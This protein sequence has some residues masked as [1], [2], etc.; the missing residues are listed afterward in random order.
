MLAYLYLDEGRF[1]FN[2]RAG[3]PGALDRSLA[4]ARRAVALDPDN[5]RALQ[6]LMVALFFHREVTEGLRVGERALALNP[7]DT[8]LMAE[9]GT[10][11]AQA[12]EW[13]RGG[14]LVAEALAR[15]PAHSGFY[16]GTLALIDYMRCDYDRALAEI[17]QANLEKFSLYH[18]VAAVIYAQE[19]LPAEARAAADRFVALQPAFVPNLDAELAERN[20]PPRD[21]AHLIDGLR[22]AGLAVPGAAGAAES[23]PAC[24]PGVPHGARAGCNLQ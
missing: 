19:G 3:R 16:R 15:N 14:R 8:E 12:G 22:K 24:E 2:P 1:A 17:R 5:I 10:R 23:C 11:V 21:R 18:G 20:F 6:A 4:A 13:E 9:F 7:N